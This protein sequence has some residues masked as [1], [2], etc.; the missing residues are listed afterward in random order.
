MFVFPWVGGHKHYLARILRAPQRSLF[1]I[2]RWYQ[3][4]CISINKG[5]QQIGNLK[6]RWITAVGNSQLAM[7]LACREQETRPFH[8]SIP[9]GKT[10]T[11]KKKQT[12]ST[13]IWMF[14]S[15]RVKDKKKKIKGTRETCQDGALSSC[16]NSSKANGL[17]K[18]THTHKFDLAALF[19]TYSSKP[20]A[21]I[22]IALDIRDLQGLYEERRSTSGGQSTYFSVRRRL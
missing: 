1:Q 12:N 21:D 14:Y 18:H 22:K 13:W 8:S 19:R 7:L 15:W 3:Q 6:E 9:E 2:L 5:L 4:S 20:R 10:N 17:I 16:S 11:H